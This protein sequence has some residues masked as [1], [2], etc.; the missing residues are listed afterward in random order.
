[1]YAKLLVVFVLVSSLIFVSA[2][3]REKQVKRIDDNTQSTSSKIDS[4][5]ISEE[6][7]TILQKNNGKLEKK[8]LQ[9]YISK[10]GYHLNSSGEGYEGFILLE[11]GDPSPQLVSALI[12]NK[13][14]NLVAYIDPNFVND[15]TGFKVT[16]TECG[17]VMLSNSFD[18][19]NMALLN[20]I[21]LK[22][23]L[24]VS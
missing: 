24:C 4:V 23:I 6:L 7:I 22:P 11:P 13:S 10:Y 16:E 20:A 3:E 18:K 17:V 14:G 9:K 15:P 2:C 1:M 19:K 12:F 5:T 8:D 21:A